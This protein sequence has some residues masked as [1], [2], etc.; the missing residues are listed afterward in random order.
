MPRTCTVCSHPKRPEV[1]SALL[2]GEPYRGIAQR[3]AASPDAVFRHRQHVA[4]ALAKAHEAAA[5]ARS[6]DLLG[7]MRELAA[8]ARRIGDAAEA[9]GQP[10]PAL[11]AI[12]EQVRIAGVLVDLGATLQEAAARAP[13]V[14]VIGTARPKE[15]AIPCP[16]R[17]RSRA[18]WP[19]WLE[20]QGR[21]RVSARTVG[22][23]ALAARATLPPGHPG[24]CPHVGDEPPGLVPPEGAAAWAAYCAERWPGVDPLDVG[25]AWILAQEWDYWEAHADEWLPPEGARPA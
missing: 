25:R 3:F 15:G 18:D 7:R 23:E 1:D 20:I 9:A 11:L 6:D 2:A 10:G 14:V 21:G 12:R 8:Q 13:G 24:H 19:R 17:L 4:P 5:V 22:R 16:F